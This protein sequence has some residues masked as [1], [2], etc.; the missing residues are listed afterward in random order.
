MSS[1]CQALWN[2][3]LASHPSKLAGSVLKLGAKQPFSLP[4]TFPHTQDGDYST[5]PSAT[6][7]HLS[8]FS[9]PCKYC[10]FYYAFLQRWL[11]WVVAASQL[12]E[13]S[14]FV[15]TALWAS[16]GAKVTWVAFFLDH[17][18]LA[19]GKCAMIAMATWQHRT[20]HRPVVPKDGHI[21][22][23]GLWMSFNK[24]F[25]VVLSANHCGCWKSS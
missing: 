13:M 10:L 5:S 19:I 17:R 14:E 23:I 12:K 6:R 15:G 18:V 21:K 2:W 7:V 25:P 4:F 3:G 24:D 9:V 20:W 16:G 11:G 22:C 1:V 8:V